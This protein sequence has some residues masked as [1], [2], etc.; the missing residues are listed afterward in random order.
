MKM[1]SNVNAQ[2]RYKQQN[3]NARMF[4]SGRIAISGEDLGQV[5]YEHVRQSIAAGKPWRLTISEKGLPQK[6]LFSWTRAT[7]PEI[8]ALRTE[9]VNAVGQARHTDGETVVFDPDGVVVSE[10]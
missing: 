5:A 2:N 8:K 4:Q 7:E 10:S 1:L 3:F 6:V 9:A